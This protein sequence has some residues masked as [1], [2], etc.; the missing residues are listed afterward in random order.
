MRTQRALTDADLPQC[1]RVADASA[2]TSQR[3]FLGIV[4]LQIACLV[5]P[6]F[7]GTIAASV[8]GQEW[9]TYVSLIGLIMLAGTRLVQRFSNEEKTWHTQRAIAEHVRSLA[10]QFAVRGSIFEDVLDPEARFDEMVER[11][12]SSDASSAPHATAAM[13][14]LRSAPFEVRRSIYA[15][16]RLDD[17]RRWYGS[18]GAKAARRAHLWDILFI[19]SSATAVVFGVLHISGAL[20][21]NLISVFGITAAVIGTWTGVRQLGSLE[22]TYSNAAE[23]LDPLSLTLPSVVAHVWPSFVSETEEV[24]SREHSSWRVNRR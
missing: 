13:R 23:N 9:L 4:K 6:V 7:A 17:Q 18:R 5:I 15:E 2:A 22:A 24:L 12:A 10:W 14:V 11:T 16:A 20:S 1:F 8:T 3:N 19:A 21:I